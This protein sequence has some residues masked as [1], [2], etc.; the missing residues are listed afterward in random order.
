MDFIPGTL[1]DTD[2]FNEVVDEYHVTAKQKGSV[3]IQM[4][5]DNGKKFIATLNNLLITLDL[6]DRFFSIVMLMSSG[7]TYMFHKEFCTVYFGA[8]QKNAV[9]LPHHALK[10]ML[11]QENQKYVKEK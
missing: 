8:D 3:Q 10:N 7:H 4:C 9:T 6:C 1:E 5:H 11:F 2:K